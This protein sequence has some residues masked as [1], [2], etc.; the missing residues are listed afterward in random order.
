MPTTLTNE[1]AKVKETALT[2][3]DDTNVADILLKLGE[4][5]AAIAPLSISADGL[6]QLGFA[7]ITTD[8]AAKFHRLVK[9]YR[10]ADF[11]RMRSAIIQHLADAQLTLTDLEKAA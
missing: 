1:T 4:I 11:P 10:A 5:N 7:H 8:P 3:V 9:L 2:Y 6:A